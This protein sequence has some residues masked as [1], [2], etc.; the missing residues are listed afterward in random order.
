[1]RGIKI[2]LCRLYLNKENM[3]FVP[4]DLNG[5]QCRRH[6]M[7]VGIKKIIRS[8]VRRTGMEILSPAIFHL[9]FLSLSIGS[10]AR[11]AETL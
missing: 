9:A 7:V 1:M 6:G 5:L 2:V 10:L 11:L 4:A 8:E 3:S